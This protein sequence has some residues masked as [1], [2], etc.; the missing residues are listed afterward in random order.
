MSSDLTSSTKIRDFESFANPHPGMIDTFSS[1]VWNFICTSQEEVSK[2][3]RAGGKWDRRTKSV[4]LKGIGIEAFL[5]LEQELLDIGDPTRLEWTR[6][7]YR[8]TMLPDLSVTNCPVKMKVQG[9]RILQEED[10]VALRRI[11]GCHFAVAPMIAAPSRKDV[12][13]GRPR[14]RRLLRSDMVRIVTCSEE[15]F[16]EEVDKNRNQLSLFPQQ[17][18]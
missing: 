16:D 15:N 7:R 8:K 6:S 5:F 14:T 11:L 12:K 3:L 2:A 4:T 9:F 17:A 10:L 13:A 1:R 18:A